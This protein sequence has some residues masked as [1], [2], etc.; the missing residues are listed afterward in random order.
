MN[1]K[2]IALATI[3]TASIAATSAAIAQNAAPAAPPTLVKPVPLVQEGRFFPG[4]GNEGLVT[5]RY[6]VKADGTTGDIE[7]LDGGFTNPFYEN[8]IKQTIAKWTFTPGTVNGEAKDFFNQEYTFRMRVGDTLGISEAGQK[9]IAEIDAALM[10]KNFQ[11]AIDAAKAALGKE[12]HSVLDYALMN[13]LLATAY[14]GLEDPFSALEAIKHATQSA[15]NMEGTREYML[16]P[17]LLEGALKQRLILAAAVRQQGEVLRTWEELDALYDIPATDGLNQ[18]VETARKEMAS[19]EQLAELGKI[20]DG[21]HWLFTP[22]HR[23][24]TAADVREGTLE[25]VV[26]HCDRRTLELEYKEGV[27]WT[28]PA[29]FGECKLDF[30]GSNGTLFTVYEFVQ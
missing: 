14:S 1:I 13:Q 17:E 9:A 10:A 12:A 28:L 20:S 21:K 8:T 26:A 6:T 15:V 4:F 5:A 23:I 30:L 16:T 7:I 2:K 24:F 25:K 3:I 29:S 19:T 27:D 22:S 11:A 18:W